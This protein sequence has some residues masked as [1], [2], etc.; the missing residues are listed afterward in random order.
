MQFVFELSFISA[1]IVMSSKSACL[2]ST[3][4]TVADSYKSIGQ[5]TRL[6]QP[7]HPE[8]RKQLS[9]GEKVSLDEL[10][11]TQKYSHFTT[12]GTNLIL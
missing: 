4:D 11:P 3:H 2:G 1:C 8:F 5:P 7:H 10:M 9:I 12:G 6:G